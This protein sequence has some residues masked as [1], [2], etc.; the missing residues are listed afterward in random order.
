MPSSGHYL[1]A[2]FFDIRVH[3][4]YVLPVDVGSI[5]FS[6][7]SSVSNHLNWAWL[8]QLFGMYTRGSAIAEGPRDALVSR[9][10]ATTKYRY[11]VALFA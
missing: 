8:V 2:L 5:H 7:I 4:L 11:R 6:D 3:S 9:N 1:D 10:S